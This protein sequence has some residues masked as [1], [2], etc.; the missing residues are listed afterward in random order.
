MRTSVD[1]SESAIDIETRLDLDRVLDSGSERF[2]G[3]FYQRLFEGFPELEEFFLGVFIQH[4]A[5]MLT[6][7]LQVMVQHY[8][9]PRR[10]SKE[11]LAV[12]G[13]RHRER[14]CFAWRL[15]EI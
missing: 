3:P 4:Q 5:A 8:R 12:L 13:N 7:A 1:S 11:Y 14:G 9:K 15:R 2:A 6:M 10:C